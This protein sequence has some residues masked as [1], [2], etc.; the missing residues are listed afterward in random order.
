MR[1]KS[2]YKFDCSAVSRWSDAHWERVEP[3]YAKFW[4]DEANAFGIRRYDHEGCQII[5]VVDW[6]PLGVELERRHEVLIPMRRGELRNAAESSVKS[7][8]EKLNKPIYI[9]ATVTVDGKNDVSKYR[10]YPAYFAEL[11]VYE[12]FL[13]ANLALPGVAQFY[14]LSFRSSKEEEPQRPR[15]SSYAFD[16]VWTRSMDGQ[17]PAIG[18][19]SFT[20]VVGWYESLNIGTKQQA[21][22]G[23]ERAIFA[24]YHLCRMDIDAESVIWIFHGLEAL[25]ATRIGENISG[26]VRRMSLLLEATDKQSNALN[27]LVRK[28]YDMRSAIVHGGYSVYHPMRSDWYG[29]SFLDTQLLLSA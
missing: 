5:V 24:V 13:V 17:W 9:K 11:Y 1:K 25:L 23:T 26:V 7:L 10:W 20:D 28:L 27:K 6:R 29:Q 14:T 8:Y 22:T 21:D 2:T 19:L 15:L 16:S 12:F 4:K 18:Q 3:L